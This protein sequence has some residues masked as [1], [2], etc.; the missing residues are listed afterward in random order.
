MGER[1]SRKAHDTKNSL[2]NIK[3]HQFEKPQ[4]KLLNMRRLS[5]EWMIRG[6]FTIKSHIDLNV[7]LKGTVQ[8]DFNF[9]F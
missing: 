8:R 5:Q 6:F 9:V 4:Q 1:V 7:L 3:Q 2:T